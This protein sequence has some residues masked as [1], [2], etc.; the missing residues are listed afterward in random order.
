M[1]K[2]S[3]GYILIISAVFSFLLLSIASLI[4]YKTIYV[5][6]FYKSWLQR[7]VL[8]LEMD[9]IL[10]VLEKKLA[11][12][13]AADFQREIKDFLPIS[14]EGKERWIIHKRAA[15]STSE[16]VWFD[17]YYIPKKQ[18]FRKGLQLNQP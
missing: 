15:D 17:F 7:R 8:F 6:N 2:T 14:I 16:P 3:R 11:E 1:R 13:P 12:L 10:A 4:F 18:N 9:S 5:D